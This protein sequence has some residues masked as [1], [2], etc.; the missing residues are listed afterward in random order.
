M[1]TGVPFSFHSSIAH[2]MLSVNCS[3]FVS[4][5]PQK[6]TADSSLLHSA[7]LITISCDSTSHP[8]SESTTSYSCCW[9]LLLTDSLKD[10][11]PTSHPL[12]NRTWNAIFL[13]LASIH[14]G[15]S[16]TSPELSI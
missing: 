5:V 14:S 11:S 6:T 3:E 1:F 12:I 13:L 9:K 7:E 10:C 8:H 15:G 4:I 2:N 16:V